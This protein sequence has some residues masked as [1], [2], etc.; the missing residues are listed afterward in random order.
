[1]RCT[2]APK[3]AQPTARAA[4]PRCARQQGKPPGRLIPEDHLRPPGKR[5]PLQLPTGQLPGRAFSPSGG[6]DPVR[7]SQPTSGR[8]AYQ[9]TAGP[10]EARGAVRQG[11]LPH[12]GG[13]ITAVNEP[14]AKP[15]V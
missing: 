15:T 13:P 5:N 12:P 7:S 10:V 9:P 14:R 2:P 8:V 4:R 3:L 11:R 6:P 1:M